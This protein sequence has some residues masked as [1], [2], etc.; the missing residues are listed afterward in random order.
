MNNL[1]IVFKLNKTKQ[2]KAK[3]YNQKNFKKFINK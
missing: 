2:S 1:T 3:N